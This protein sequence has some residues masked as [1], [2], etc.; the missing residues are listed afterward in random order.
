MAG[1]DALIGQTVSHYRILKKLGGGGMGVVY[2]AED[3]MLGRHVALKFLPDEPSKDRQALERFQREARAASALNH[4]NICTIHEVGEQHGQHFIVM[5][6]LDGMT[7]KHRIGGKPM[8][9]GEVLLLGLE[10]TDALDAA[11]STGIVHRDIKPANIFVTKRGHA[12]ILDFGLAK[13]SSPKN[14]KADATTLALNELDPDHLTSPGS[15]LGTVAYMSPEQACAKQLDPRTD[16]FSLGVVLYEMATG[17]LP[18]RGDSS[19]MIFDSLL[20]RAPLPPRRLNPKIP[21]GLERIINKS[22]E[23]DRNLRYQHASEMGTDLRRLRRDLEHG[24]AAAVNLREAQSEIAMIASP[25]GSEPIASISEPGIAERPRFSAGK[26][27]VSIAALVS[28]LIVGGLYWLSRRSV[29]LTDKDTVV[30][31]EFT[32]T[33]GDPVFD[34]TLRQGLSVQL[35]QSPFLSVVSDQQIQQTLKMMGQRPDVKLTP[36]IVQEVCQRTGSAAVLD[37]SIAQIGTRYLLTLKAANCTN[38]GT[39]ASTEAEAGNRNLVLDALGKIAAEIRGK[40]GESLSTVQKFDTPLEQAT[41]PSLEALKAYTL[42]ERALSGRGSSAAIP[43][44]ERAIELDPKFASAEYSL[45]G[46]YRNLNQPERAAEHLKRAAFELGARLSERE[47]LSILASYY[48]DVTGETEKAI[49][50]NELLT[51]SYPRNG[52]TF[53]NL[54]VLYASVG[55]YEKAIEATRQALRLNPD[56]VANYENLGIPYLALNRFSEA[57]DI[58]AQALKRKLDD[59]GL[60]ANLYAL[61]FLN[62]DWAGMAQQATWFGERPDLENEALALES[63]TQAYFGKLKNARK[64]TRRAVVS[65]QRAQNVESAALAEADG[66]L[67]EALFGNMRSAR[68]QATQ[69]LKLAPGSR[70]AE[71]ESALALALAGDR[72]RAHLLANR[73][74]KRFPLNTQLRSYWLP[75]IQSQIFLGSSD[76]AAAIESLQPV[77]TYDTENTMFTQNPS[78]MFPTYIRGQAFLARHHGTAAAA[79]F[80]NLLNHRG[81]VWNCS[82]GSLA[83]LGIARAY[84]LQGDI[85]KAQAAYQDFLTLWTDADPDIPVLREAKAEY[86]KLQ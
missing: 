69:A 74:A 78:C 47:R 22:L 40:L 70:Y 21:A 76:P 39:L 65:C 35:E 81:I 67:R 3:L 37:G 48:M 12:K 41:T 45:G 1:S 79:E 20:N 83:H 82:T 75:T 16:L 49:R 9:V 36:E 77:S 72:T 80:Q 26:I 14:T 31:A 13:V 43:F 25:A 33:T 66:A 4:P 85:T 59:D 61:A 84:A 55:Q 51:Q 58:T 63:A 68:E 15:T 73:L 19:A 2:E 50:T 7:L 23:K 56:K 62:G 17:Q 30:L 86:A 53:G 18:F 44:F 24:R 32:N 34:G 5:E 28:C 46:M 6:F 71:I 27:L 60:H 52:A 29:N 57:L 54:G 8:E 10:I 11:H 38:G 64:L 42:G